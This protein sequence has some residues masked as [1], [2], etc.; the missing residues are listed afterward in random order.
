MKSLQQFCVEV[1]NWLVS[2]RRDCIWGRL[3]HNSAGDLKKTETG[4]EK[5]HCF[6]SH[7]LSDA[8][9][10]KSLGDYPQIWYII[11]HCGSYSEHH[12]PSTLYSE[13]VTGQ[14]PHTSI[15]K[16]VSG[17]WRKL[18]ILR[19]SANRPLMMLSKQSSQTTEGTDEEGSGSGA[20]SAERAALQ[21][22]FNK[23]LTSSF[24]ISN[25]PFI[26][27]MQAPDLKSAQRE[28]IWEWGHLISV[29][30]ENRTS[31]QQK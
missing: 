22:K 9:K 7:H 23:V 19:C 2:Y 8:C 12:P 15:F 20:R 31:E 25:S 1:V 27:E 3:W 17:W 18:K 21:D 14:Q 5:S 29:S 26:P 4:S 24:C 6:W 16:S 13:S 11:L 10:K 28:E 30:V